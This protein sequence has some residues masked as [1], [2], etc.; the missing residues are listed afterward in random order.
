MRL[1]ACLY[2]TDAFPVMMK[3]SDVPY[4][5][6]RI[7]SVFAATDLYDMSDAKTFNF[8]HLRR[9]V[10]NEF[11]YYSSRT[12]RFVFLDVPKNREGLQSI[13]CTMSHQAVEGL[14]QLRS[15]IQK[16]ELAVSGTV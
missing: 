14:F 8:D 6:C 11:K 15:D 3:K 1:S 9:F 10:K 2:R 16:P 4:S 12:N 5:P 13:S 7:I